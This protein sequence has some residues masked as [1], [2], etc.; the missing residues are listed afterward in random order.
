MKNHCVD[1]SGRQ[2]CWCPGTAD[3][4]WMAGNHAGALRAPRGTELTIE[5]G[6]SQCLNVYQSKVLPG[7]KGIGMGL[8][9]K[10]LGSVLLSEFTGLGAFVRYSRDCWCPLDQ[11]QELQGRTGTQQ[12]W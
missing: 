6:T 4:R 1:G 12:H 3:S 2:T 8:Q 10:R 7:S 11:R 5:S 9:V